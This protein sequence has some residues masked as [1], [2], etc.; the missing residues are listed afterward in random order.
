MATAYSYIRFSSAK[1]Q[2]G[3]SLDRQLEI[4]KNYAEKKGLLLDPS[5]YR[6]LGVSAWKAKNKTEGALGAFISAVDDGTIKKGS[7]LLIESFDR[8]SRDNHARALQLLLD[9]TNKGITVVTLIDEQVYNTETIER[10][11]EKLVLALIY[12]SRANEESETK[13]KRIK[14]SFDRKKA[15]GKIAVTKCPTWLELNADRT[16]YL[17]KP[18]RAAHCKRMFDLAL[19]GH[20]GRHI[21]NVL[22]EE[23]VKPF[24]WGK[25]MTRVTVQ[26]VLTNPATY[27]FRPGRLGGEDHYPAI[28]TK[29]DFD[30]VQSMFSKRRWKVSKVDDTR[31]LFSGLLYCAECGGRVR[32]RAAQAY[33]V[34]NNHADFKS[35]KER[36][37]MDYA[38][39]EKSVLYSIARESKVELL[40]NLSKEQSKREHEIRLLIDENRVKQD[41]LTAAIADFGY[42]DSLRE[43]MR[44]LKS[45]A[46]ALN[47]ELLT[48][49]APSEDELGKM[50]DTFS[51]YWNVVNSGNSDKG[52][53]RQIKAGVQRIVRSL[54]CG[55]MDDLPYVLIEYVSGDKVAANP[56][57]FLNGHQSKRLETK[58]TGVRTRA[59]ARKP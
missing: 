21:A 56:V 42:T 32:T 7:W 11:I 30:K 38:A 27:G 3:T 8:L 47:R 14:E 17:L 45:D 53:R 50:N 33:L 29:A 28:V 19:Q 26:G 36:R 22:H 10:G 16:G 15:Q 6:D 51:K 41:N 52:L 54:T 24:Q 9:L 1:Q 55:W 34:C 58:R 2:K 4:A 46:D 25:R 35:C 5:N 59:R 48:L 39:V 23:G 13:S 37:H 18:E 40:Q 57:M 43:K 49:D 20:S 44:S 12:M 31:N